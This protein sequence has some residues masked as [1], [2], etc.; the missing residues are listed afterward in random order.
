MSEISKLYE[1]AE[2]KKQ[3][4][5]VCSSNELYCK[6]CEAHIEDAMPY[7]KNAEYPTFTAEKQL[8]LIKWLLYNTKVDCLNMFYKN[9]EN[10]LEISINCQNGYS[11]ENSFDDNFEIAIASTINTLWQDLT[12]EE[13]KQIKEILE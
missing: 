8:E 2:V 10:Y 4:P 6:E 9:E 7:C 5:K 13:R 12:E 11:Y 1:N 3:I